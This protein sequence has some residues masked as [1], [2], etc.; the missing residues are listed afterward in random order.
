MAFV[1]TQRCCNDAS[2][3]S[4]CPVD[5]IRPSPDDPEF[6]TAEMLH[7]DPKACVDCGACVP[8]CPTSAIDYEVDLP[9]PLKRCGKAVPWWP[10]PWHR[11]R[12]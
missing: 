6:G 7:I 1:I 12:K 3:V 2:C 11:C 10:R 4:V 5:C 9:E 8:V